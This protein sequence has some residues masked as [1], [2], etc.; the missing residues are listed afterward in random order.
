[1]MNYNNKAELEKAA[2]A[3]EN[4]R[5][6]ADLCISENNREMTAD[7]ERQFDEYSKDQH[8]W[9]AAAERK[10]TLNKVT[11]QEVEKVEEKAEKL[12]KSVGEIV[13]NEAQTRELMNRW[14]KGTLT[15]ED[16]I[17]FRAQTTQT[18]T[19]GGFLIPEQWSNEITKVMQSFGGMYS[20]ASVLRT[21]NGE[22]FNYPSMTDVANNGAWLS[23]NT[24]AAA[25]DMAF[26]NVAFNAYKASSDYVLAP[27][28][29]MQDSTYDMVGFITDVIGERLARRC[30][31]G[32][33]AGSGSSEPSGVDDTSAF[34]AATDV[35]VVVDFDDLLDLKH[36]VDP[37]YR[38]SGKATWMLN[39]TVMRDL[40]KVAI[41]SANQSLWQPGI[42]GGEPATIDGDFYTINQDLPD[43]AA[44]SHSVLYGL[45]SKYLIREAGG[46]TIAQ[47]ND[48]YILEDQT[49]FV[50]F[51]RV[52]GKLLDTT[53][54]KHL[55][56]DNT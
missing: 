16:K 38:A 1:M 6:I 12:V 45:F 32:F 15:N 9:E 4:M 5:A 14:L 13:N 25:Q 17:Q 34:G 11:S 40:K 39:D 20:V 48:R 8:K 46:T 10:T 22:A 37:A 29:L 44:G 27:N 41:A 21:E 35:T 3:V 36:S 54:V 2:E 28:E 31:L 19:S 53:A 42:V 33:T 49:A 55:R 43:I 24:A 30:N 51:K 7:E 56:T 23:E 18:D 50:G 26:T 47:S 52:D